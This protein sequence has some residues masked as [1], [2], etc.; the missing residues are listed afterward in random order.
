MW[1]FLKKSCFLFLASPNTSILQSLGQFCWSHCKCA[2][3]W[4]SY[5]HSDAHLKSHPDAYI[6]RCTQSSL[7]LA[8]AQT[9][10][11]AG[12][13]DQLPE[14]LGKTAGTWTGTLSSCKFPFGF[15]LID[16]RE[17]NGAEVMT[18]WCCLMLSPFCGVGCVYVFLPTGAAVGG[19]QLVLG[20]HLFTQLGEKRRGIR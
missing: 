15:C 8:E 19:E 12:E 6:R 1:V 5:S 3:Y 14:S 7:F 9:L 17:S 16:N 11:G 18:P 4:K 13:A 10:K 2:T 20:N